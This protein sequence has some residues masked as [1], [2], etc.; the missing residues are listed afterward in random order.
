MINIP[1]GTKDVL[2]AEAYKA[3]FADGPDAGKVLVDVK[4]VLDKAAFAGY[5]YWRL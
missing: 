2:P 4:S 3:M 5:R 1:K